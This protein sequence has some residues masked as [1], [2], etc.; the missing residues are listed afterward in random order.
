MT[1]KDPANQDDTPS[2]DRLQSERVPDWL[3]SRL[4][5]LNGPVMVDAVPSELLALLEQIESNERQSG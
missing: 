4:R 3:A 2:E 5:R 1:T